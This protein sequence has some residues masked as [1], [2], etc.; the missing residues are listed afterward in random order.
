MRVP[1]LPLA[2]FAA[3]NDGCAVVG[4]DE[5]RTRD[6]IRPLKGAR[7]AIVD[8]DSEVLPDDNLDASRSARFAPDE[9]RAIEG[10]DLQPILEPVVTMAIGVE[11]DRI[12]RGTPDPAQLIAVQV[13]VCLAQAMVERAQLVAIPLCAAVEA[14][15]LAEDV[16][17]VWFG[18]EAEGNKTDEDWWV[19]P[20]ARATG[21]TILLG[22]V[23]L[24]DP[25]GCRDR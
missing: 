1:T 24:R 20:T 11:E 10:P 22:L 18:H 17:S 19:D 23:N 14:G 25:R 13:I 9:A 12:K 21:K 7:E 5:G 16:P 8:D 6:V 2:A 15:R 3:A 4:R